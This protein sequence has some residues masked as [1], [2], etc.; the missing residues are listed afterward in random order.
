[1]QLKHWLY[2]SFYKNQKHENFSQITYFGMD[3]V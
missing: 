1:M 3:L 2:T